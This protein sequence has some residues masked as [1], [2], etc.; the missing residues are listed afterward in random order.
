MPSA[1][2]PVGLRHR[3]TRSPIGQA[4]AH[5][6]T[7]PYRCG[8]NIHRNAREQGLHLSSSVFVSPPRSRAV[9]VCGACVCVAFKLR[10]PV[11][12]QQRSNPEKKDIRIK[13]S[14]RCRK[15]VSFKRR[16][17]H[18]LGQL[19]LIQQ[20]TEGRHRHA[21]I[22]CRIHSKS[23]QQEVARTLD[24]GLHTH[25]RS[26][27]KLVAT[28]V[29][30]SHLTKLPHQRQGDPRTRPPGPCWRRSPARARCALGVSAEPSWLPS[31]S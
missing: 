25:V 3:N 18:R 21:E 26:Y 23:M 11:V 20:M 1:N 2:R 31:G 6:D 28:S 17:W 22:T 30:E 19:C 29:H 13:S 27:I 9:P 16:R 5:E 12:Q 24:Y 7:L 14:E 10:T 15:A 8:M 4:G